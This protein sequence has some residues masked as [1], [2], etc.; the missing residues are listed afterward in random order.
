MIRL[1]GTTFTQRIT[2]SIV[3][4][5]IAHELHTKR[6]KATQ[7]NNWKSIQEKYKLLIKEHLH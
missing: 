5:G 4:T 6:G 1:L 3:S 7:I 2:A